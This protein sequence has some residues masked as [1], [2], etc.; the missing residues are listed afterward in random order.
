[1][2]NNIF[3]QDCIFMAGV[4]NVNGFP[5]Y[6]FPEVAFI[7]RSNVGKSS[8]INSITNKNKLAR[9]SNFPGR[10]RQVNFFNLGYKI[11]L[12]DLPGYG[13]A[14]ISKVELKNL[15]TLIQTYVTKRSK[16]K[17]V[18]LLVDARHGLKELDTDIMKE[19]DHAA[20]AYQIVLTKCDKCSKQNLEALKENILATQM[21]HPAMNAKII[22]TSSKEKTGI[23]TL[24]LEILDLL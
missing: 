3:L 18:F 17:R 22:M 6:D 23:E 9:V 13:Y 8:I 5:N 21:N 15:R 20:T 14:K 19:M 11:I 7:G 12:V 16:L 4:N 24:R 1:M 10:T 2:H